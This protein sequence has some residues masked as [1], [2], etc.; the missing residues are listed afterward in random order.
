MATATTPTH[1]PD[2]SRLARLHRS[3]ADEY[4]PEPA[5]VERA[6]IV[7]ARHHGKDPDRVLAAIIEAAE[8][9]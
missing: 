7:L 6:A 4:A 8:A 3:I 9:A 5:D 1:A 2:L